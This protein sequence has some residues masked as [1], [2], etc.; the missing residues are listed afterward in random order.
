MRSPL[1]GAMRRA[2]DE[3]GRFCDPMFLAVYKSLY[4]RSVVG[5]LMEAE[6]APTVNDEIDTEYVRALTG[7]CDFWFIALR[8]AAPCLHTGTNW[9]F[10]AAVFSFMVAFLNDFIDVLSFCK[11]AIDGTDFRAG[12]VYRRSVQENISYLDSC[13][14]TF[15]SG[16]AAHRRILRLATEE[17][18]PHLDRYMTGFIYWH[19]RSARYGWQAIRPS[20]T[21]ID[22]AL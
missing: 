3:V 16:V 12:L 7:F 1:A 22:M 5:V 4:C 13:R 15:D 2:L 9:G 10:W 17:Q 18:R 19:L 20:V 14:R 6:F 21:S 8:F 11:E